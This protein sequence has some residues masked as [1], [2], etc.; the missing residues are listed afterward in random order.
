MNY[1]NFGYIY[2]DDVLFNNILILSAKMKFL[3]D[4]LTKKDI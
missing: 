1:N 3:I 2:K 4:I